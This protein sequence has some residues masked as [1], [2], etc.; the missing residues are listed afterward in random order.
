MKKIILFLPILILGIAAT[1]SDYLNTWL[2]DEMLQPATVS[3]AVYDLD[4]NEYVL[5]HNS[6]K[7]LP[8][9]SVQ[10]LITTTIALK[11]LGSDHQ[12][13]TILAYTGDI[14]DGILRGDI[15]IF[16]N[17]NPTLA[18]KRFG[19]NISEIT[20]AIK[21][22]LAKNN[23]KVI[24]GIKVVDPTMKSETLPR[25]WIWEDIGNYYGANP[26]G[27]VLNEN[28][29]ELH[30]ESGAAGEPTKIVKTIPD[31]P[32]LRVT[33]R[34]LSSEKNRDLAYAFGGPYERG[35][36]V[37]GTIPANR[38]NFKVKAAL[39]NPQKALA[40]L[41]YEELNNSPFFTVK[42]K[43]G[44]LE[45]NKRPY[46]Q[47]GVVKSASVND[48]VKKTNH[49]SI[50]ILAE[51]LLQNSHMHSGSQK[52]MGIWA[53]DYLANNLNINV[54]GMQLKDGSGL[55]R[56]NAISSK[57]LVELLIVMKDNKAFRN[58]LPTAS[59]SGT[60]KSFLK[61]S[62][63]NVRCK[64][65]SMQGVRS[66]AGYVKTKLGRKFAFSVIINNADAKGS[67]VK[68]KIEELLKQVGGL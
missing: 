44:T 65:G 17:F 35:L 52:T 8:A 9:A 14:K 21:S 54:A 42:G 58:S 22:W 66:Y 62:S 5:Q 7:V 3:L 64:S 50:N 45:K 38:K 13:E 1:T 37:E 2:S 27:T 46:K 57:Q 26:C 47:F 49:K 43:Y 12:F 10:K 19:K 60:V 34:V 33:N 23:V 39:Q 16:P 15:Y 51:N 40:Y 56:F 25:T 48:I 61:N 11:T 24:A 67:K 55:S 68:K 41:V 36:V 53:K 63:L 59:K 31:L 32:L 30:F 29:L 4:S 6:Q 28:I 18:N 20:G